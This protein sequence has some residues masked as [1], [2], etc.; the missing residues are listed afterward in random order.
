MTERT[1]E[2]YP[3][4]GQ[5]CRGEARVHCAQGLPSHVLRS[6]ESNDRALSEKERDKIFDTL[7]SE[8][9]VDRAPAEVVATLLDEDVYLCSERTMY[10]VLDSREAVQERRA[11]RSHPRIQETRADGDGPEPC[12]VLGY[13]AAAGAEEVELLLP[14]RHPGHLQPLRP[15]M[16]GGG[17]GE[18]RLGRPAWSLL[19]MVI[20]PRARARLKG[21]L[22]ENSPNCP[23]GGGRV[24]P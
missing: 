12:L 22:R 6:S 24:A 11:Q 17:S 10:R 2:G 9:F 19:D 21:G 14:L 5:A 20:H 7:C 23:D 16:D 8:R 15:G 3:G 13:H 1:H 18:L 4:T